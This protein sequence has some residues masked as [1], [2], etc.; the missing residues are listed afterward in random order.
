[1]SVKEKNHDLFD[2]FASKHM[3]LLNF[4]GWSSGPRQKKNRGQYRFSKKKESNISGMICKDVSNNIN[5][6]YQPAPSKN[7]KLSK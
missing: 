1:M 4:K 5:M 2:C 6:I 3:Q 7:L